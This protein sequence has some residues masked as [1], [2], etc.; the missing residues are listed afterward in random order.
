[1]RA[2]DLQK[3][4]WAGGGIRTC[5]F[6]LSERGNAQTDVKLKVPTVLLFNMRANKPA[7]HVQFQEK[8]KTL[9]LMKWIF[10][11]R[12]VFSTEIT[13]LLICETLFWSVICKSLVLLKISKNFLRKCDFLPKVEVLSKW[14]ICW[15]IYGQMGRK[16]LFNWE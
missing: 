13:V 8:E 12:L 14:S 1:M 6:W 3:W 2:E 16:K 15:T 10:S 9:G 4:K 7:R 5:N 11:L